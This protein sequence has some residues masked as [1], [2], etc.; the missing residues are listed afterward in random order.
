VRPLKSL[1]WPIIGL[2]A[3]FTP[4]ILSAQ[5]TAEQTAA[6]KDRAFTEFFR[7]TAGWT[8]G[9]GALSVPLSD[10]RVLWLFGDS[11]VDDIDP[12]SG[13]MPCLFQTRSAALI[14][15]KTDLQN[16]RTLIGQRPGFRSWFKNPVRDNEWFWPLCG[17]QQSNTVYVYL[18]ALRK[19]ATGGMWGFE[20]TE[21]DYWAK[22]K[23]PEMEPVSYR[24]LPSFNGITFGHGLVNDGTNVYAF[25]GKKKGLASEVYVARFKTAD[26]EG[27]WNF[28]D[29]HAWVLNVTNALPIARGASTS[30]HVCKVK[31]RFL[32]TTSAFS[33]ACDQG[34]EIYL[35]TSSRPTLVDNTHSSRGTARSA[36]PTHRSA[37]PKP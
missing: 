2:T 29:G 32:L 14:H 18:A 37:C 17:F 4:C 31:N 13:T 3:L 24:P 23:F 35:A 19:T 21:Q 26:P 5:Q 9:D 15:S 16:P 27:H 25:G 28:W 10:G 30:L 22:V 33:V 20:S 12:A 7:R 6:H 1:A 34:K 8:A 11:H 36:S